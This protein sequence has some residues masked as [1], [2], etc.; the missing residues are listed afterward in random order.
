MICEK[1]CLLVA[2]RA[3][4]RRRTQRG[5]FNLETLKSEEASSTHIAAAAATTK[6]DDDGRRWG[7][8][9]STRGVRNSFLCVLRLEARAPFK[10]GGE[11]ALLMLLVLRNPRPFFSPNP[12]SW[13][14]FSDCIWVLLV[15]YVH[16]WRRHECVCG[17]FL[18]PFSPHP[19]SLL[20]TSQGP[21]QY[22]LRHQQQQKHFSS[23]RHNNL[24][25]P[26]VL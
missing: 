8:I 17:W 26:S 23:G 16:T 19:L 1:L 14:S 15:Y 18:L 6:K 2:V 7:V 11:D 20:K 13:C 10:K 3:E 12:A 9:V 22:L 21:S 5:G 25:R 24:L 4:H